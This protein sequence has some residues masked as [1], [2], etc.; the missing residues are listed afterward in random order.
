MTSRELLIAASRGGEVPRKPVLCW[1]TVVD[2]VTD[3]LVIDGS[4]GTGGPPVVST[5]VPGVVTSETELASGAYRDP[6]KV[7]LGMVPGV[8]E[9]ARA[10]S[11]N[12]NEILSSDPASGEAILDEAMNQVRGRIGSALDAGM[13]GIF[14]HLSGATPQAASPMQYG[15]HYLERDRDILAGVADATL[16]VLFVSGGPGVYLDFV[17][18][19]PAHIF[20]WDI[21]GSRVSVAEVR[22]MRAGA[23]LA[24]SPEADVILT[25]RPHLP[26]HLENQALAGV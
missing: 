3:A 16:N 11:P 24:A 17:S 19:L 15:G 23:L 18:D 21:E 22:A 6:E 1:P 14:Y 25:C 10:I 13:D 5:P 20:G 9:T 26:T 4:R 8:F 7:A 2:A 12:L